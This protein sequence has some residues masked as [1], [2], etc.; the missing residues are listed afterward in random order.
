MNVDAYLDDWR[1]T[2]SISYDLT[3]D[4]FIKAGIKLAGCLS[5]LGDDFKALIEWA[6]T[7]NP[8]E[9]RENW[10]KLPEYIKDQI[11]PCPYAD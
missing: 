7:D 4:D 2:L 1:T 11:S 10:D 9:G 3:K 6:R 8:I 5:G